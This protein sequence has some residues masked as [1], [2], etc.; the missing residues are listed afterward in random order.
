[1]KI[2]KLKVFAASTALAL[3]LLGSGCYVKLEIKEQPQYNEKIKNENE[4]IEKYKNIMEKI[5]KYDKLVPGKDYA[6]ERIMLGFDKGATKE[7]ANKFI[8]NQDLTGEL[9]LLEYYSEIELAV[10]KV[11]KE[12]EK[13]YALWFQNMSDETIVKY[14]DLDYI[15]RIQN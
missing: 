15:I 8:E 2:T 10:V 5:I 11:P 3:S 7:E 6:E 13:S 12:Q 1:M 14:A 9:E 4:T